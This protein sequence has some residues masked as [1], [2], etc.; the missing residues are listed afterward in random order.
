MAISEQERKKWDE[1][2]RL[3]IEKLRP[4][5][6]VRPQLD[7][8]YS[9]KDQSIEIFEIRPGWDNP[10]KTM[11]HSVAKA[12]WV[13]SQKIWKVYWKRSDLKWHEYKPTPQVD[14]LEAF[15]KVVE[16]DRYACFWG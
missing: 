9:I 2:T 5:K 16:E 3:F 4:P 12:T 7:L 10:G 1:L 11:E 8:G 13:R 15:L 6:E 14:T